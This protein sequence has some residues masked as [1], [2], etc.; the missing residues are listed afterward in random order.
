MK[1]LL[2][3]LLAGA[4]IL[5]LA[6]LFVAAENIRMTEAEIEKHISIM[7][8]SRCSIYDQLYVKFNEG[9]EREAAIAMLQAEWAAL[10]PDN[11]DKAADAVVSFDDATDY[12]PAHARIS[13]KNADMKK[14]F[15]LLYRHDE[16]RSVEVERRV[17]PADVQVGDANYDGRVDAT[18]C[19]VL[20][21]YILGTLGDNRFRFDTADID[22]NRV[23]NAVD[24]LLLKRAY[25]GTY[26]LPGY[27]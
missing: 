26:R 6:S 11:A 17:Q 1:K 24:Y 25:L 16:I 22:N 2:S 10:Y 15:L 8:E 4:I 3:L 23:I 19:L 5:S 18:D 27:F 12:Y 13:V 7:L 9:T 14:M 21:R 20:K